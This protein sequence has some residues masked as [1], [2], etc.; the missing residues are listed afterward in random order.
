MTR[1]GAVGGGKGYVSRCG[2]GGLALQG[3]PAFADEWGAAPL[4]SGHATLV[5]VV[6]SPDVGRPED[7]TE[8]G[9]LYGAGIGTV[10]VQRAV[11]LPPMVVVEVAC[12]DSL[13]VALIEDK[14]RRSQRRPDP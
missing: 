11:N 4:P 3:M 2:A 9:R 7:V 6:K 13:Q 5:V 1:K 12:T 14:R 8:L 10:H